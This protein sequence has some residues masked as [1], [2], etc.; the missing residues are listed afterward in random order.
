MNSSPQ[1]RIATWNLERPKQNGWVKNQRRLDKIRE[2]DADVWVLT[3][4]NTAIALPS[5]CEAV[6]SAS[7]SGYHAAGENL[8]TIWSRLKVL[9]SIPTFDPAWAVC[10]EVDSPLGAMIIYGTV[11]TFANDKGMSGTAK[12]WEEHRRFIQR[13]HEDWLRI[14][15]QYPN[16]LMCVSADFN[17]SRDQSGWYEEKQSVE[18]LS[19]ALHDLSMVCVTEENLQLKGFS[20]ST[21]DHICLSERLISHQVEVGAWEGTTQEDGKMSDH[22]GVFVDLRRE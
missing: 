12:R 21:V 1:L 10:A 20:R 19:A 3:E 17:Q 22:N 8:S 13:H 18:M 9:R 2:I 5:D 6:T 14:Q 16:H 4:T 7:I 15:K 11:I